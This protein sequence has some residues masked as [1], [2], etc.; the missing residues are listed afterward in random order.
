MNV[1]L[2]IITIAAAATAH[3]LIISILLVKWSNKLSN[4]LLA[5]TLFFLSIR[6][7]SCIIGITNNN[8]QEIMTFISA[9]SVLMVGPLFYY[10]NQGLRNPFLKIL[11]YDALHLIPASIALFFLPFLSWPVVLIFHYLAILSLLAYVILAIKKKKNLRFISNHDKLLWTWEKYYTLG[12]LVITSLFVLQIFL[13]NPEVYLIVV[14]VSASIFYVLSIVAMKHAK[15]I[16]QLPKK[17]YAPN[18]AT[19]VLGN[20][21]KT[22]IID[23]HEY[24]DPLISVS[25]LAKRLNQPP[26]L[27]SKSINSFFGKSFPVLLNELRIEKAKQLLTDHKMK[28]Q[29]IDTIA[30]ESGFTTMSA[31]YS[32]FKKNTLNTPGQ[33]R[34][35]NSKFKKL[36]I[37]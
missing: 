14:L 24:T 21:L 33:Y 30:L 31:F 16:L 6:I 15:G 17:I 18:K 9:I 5:L 22:I 20:K 4:R 29:T 28:D 35:L 34:K 7:G 10:Y 26:Y 11:T 3:C 2:I 8:Y 19:Q 27:V 36:K 23:K 37:T 12:I 1:I 32:S 25:R 13:E